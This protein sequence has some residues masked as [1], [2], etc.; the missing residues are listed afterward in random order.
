MLKLTPLKWF[1]VLALLAIVLALG[2]PPDP[3]DLQQLHAS[4]T[5]YRLALVV[6]LI[7][8]VLIWYA[9]FYAFAKVR[10]YSAPLRGS[11]DGDAF[12]T[13]TIGMG[14]LAFGLIVP[15]IVSLILN[16]IASHTLSFEAAA[17]VISNYFG[18]FPGMLAFLLLLN[19][20]RML[21]RTT[22][23][24]AEKLDLRWHAPWFLLLAVLFSHLTIENYYRGDPYHLPLW[25][26]VIS[27]IVPYLYGWAVGILSGYD[28]RLYAGTVKG[29]LYRRAIK[30]FANGILITIA[31][32]VAIQFVDITLMQRADHSLGLILLI[33]Y[34]LLAIVAVGLVSIAMG[35]KKLK[36]IEEV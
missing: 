13:I 36:L 35:T 11:K 30:Q 27:F 14:V 20:A 2:L 5:A 3:H 15:T 34:I 22:R 18:L 21:L 23:R 25:L 10:E 26:L 24:G 29:S 28:L 12:R 8:Y 16:N 7:P 4:E 9:S 32:S 33:D 31:G 17:V 6:L 1:V 19:G